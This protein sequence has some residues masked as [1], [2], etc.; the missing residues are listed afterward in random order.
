M[1]KKKIGVAKGDGIGPELVNE[2]LKIMETLQEHT[3]F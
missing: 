1:E 2:G 3:D